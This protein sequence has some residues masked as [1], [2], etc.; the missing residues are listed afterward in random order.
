VA[1]A[2]HA[3]PPT[4][5]LDIVARD[6]ALRLTLDP[7]FHL[8]GTAGGSDVDV[9]EDADPRVTSVVGFLDAVRAGDPALVGC[10]PADALET[11]RVA[12][13]AERSI[14]EGRPISWTYVEGSD[15]R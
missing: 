4:Y 7:E 11:L 15:R 2:E 10:T 12:L 9:R 13:A 14:A 6:A 8:N 5:T 3:E 1:W